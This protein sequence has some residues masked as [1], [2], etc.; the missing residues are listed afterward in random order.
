MANVRRFLR[1]DLALPVYVEPCDDDGHP[2]GLKEQD[3]WPAQLRFHL[4][5]VDERLQQVLT[6]LGQDSGRSAYVL[7]QFNMR[8][9]FLAWL[10]ARLA[11]NEDPKADGGFAFRLREDGKVPPPALSEDSKVGHLLHALFMHIDLAIREVVAVVR[12]SHDR[13]FVFPLN[14]VEPFDHREYVANLEQVSERGSLLAKAILLLEEKLNT[15]LAVLAR[16]KEFYRLRADVRAW[17][18]DTVNLSAGGIGLWRAEALPLFSP[19]NVFVSLD[20]GVFAAHG[21]VVFCRKLKE[22]DK[23]W[24]IGIDF[25]WLPVAQQQRMTRFLQRRELADTMKRFPDFPGLR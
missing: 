8:L 11:E 3:L 18:V 22:G 6:A 5:G 14:P 9:N 2:L 10:L 13:L 20:D 19:V 15:L 21:K 25:E 17:P 12:D 7:H 4:D 23:P 16:F 1:Y 24:R